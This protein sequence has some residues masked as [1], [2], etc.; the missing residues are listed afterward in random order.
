[1]QDISKGLNDSLR[2]SLEL[3]QANNRTA[4]KTLNLNKELIDKK[5]AADSV[6]LFYT[7]NRLQSAFDSGWKY[8]SELTELEKRQITKNA[9]DKIIPLLY[10]E[11][12]N[13]FLIKNYK[14]IPGW[15]QL[16]DSVESIL[17]A[18]E[19]YHEPDGYLEHVRLSKVYWDVFM[20][21]RRQVYDLIDRRRQYFMNKSRQLHK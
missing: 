13:A 10:Q 12:D 17:N 8:R 19:Y 15:H 3:Q 7:L 1:L 9:L 5:V 6:R 16:Q 14:L 18:F 11:Y 2:H 21:V 20:K 4:E